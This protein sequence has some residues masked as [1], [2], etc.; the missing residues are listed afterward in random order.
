MT[1]E[2]PMLL[3]TLLVVPAAAAL[4][5]L[6]QRRHMRYAVSFT[7]LDVLSQ[8]VGRSGWRRNLPPTLFAIAL[9][10]LCVAVARPQTWTLATTEESTV[11]LVVDASLSMLATDVKPSRLAAAQTA[12]RS[13]L[14]RVP[15]RL[16]VGLVVFAGEAQV[17]APP[18]TDRE[19]VRESV[20][21]IG[22]TGAFGG[23]A[24]G[25]ALV[26][27]VELAG[28]TVGTT[29]GLASI[30]FLSDGRQNRGNVQPL[31]AARRARQAGMRVYTIA[32][33]TEHGRLPVDEG[34]RASSRSLAPDPATLRAISRVTGGEFFRARSA[35]AL[36]SA[37]AG[38]GTRL[39]G[40]PRETEI[41]YAFL[42]AAGALLLAS[43]V[44]S[45]LW[46][47]RLP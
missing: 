40:K 19:L 34:V 21:S 31:E 22:S 23:T 26:L 2:S 41:T 11:V 10:S 14:T 16:R 15:S 45:V 38:L 6:A 1:F 3:L 7:N 44:L 25:D 37:Y 28:R 27:A 17:G 33:G 39:G 43:T 8:V 36:Q 42:A 24:I 47:P 5:L 4:Y 20:D 30:L 32:L 46:S 9:V 13:F 35:Q 29:R 18:A 12:V